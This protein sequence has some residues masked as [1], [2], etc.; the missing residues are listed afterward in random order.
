MLAAPGGPG[1]GQ[2]LRRKGTQLH[3]PDDASALL[4]TVREARVII[5]TVGRWLGVQDIEDDSLCA[6]LF[7]EIGNDSVQLAR[8]RPR[9]AVHVLAPGEALVVEHDRDDLP[10]GLSRTLQEPRAH[11]PRAVLEYI[12]GPREPERRRHGGRN[13]PDDA[14]LKKLGADQEESLRLPRLRCPRGRP[15]SAPDGQPVPAEAL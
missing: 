4:Q 2:P 15:G 9:Q 14:S 10:G 7:A 1:G 11:V 13:D 6:A 12:Q 8:P 3:G 5:H